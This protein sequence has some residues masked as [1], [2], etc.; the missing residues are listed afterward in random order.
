MNSQ[1]NCQEIYATLYYDNIL[2]CLNAIFKGE[3]GFAYEKYCYN[4]IPRSIKRV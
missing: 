3:F 4:G 2:P 1:E